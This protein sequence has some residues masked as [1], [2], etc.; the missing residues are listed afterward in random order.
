MEQQFIEGKTFN[1]A[2]FTKNGLPSGDYDGCTF[3]NL[4][5]HDVNFKGSDMN[6]PV[7]DNCCLRTVLSENSN[8]EKCDFRTS[9]DY[10]PDPER[11][12][13]RKSR[14]SLSVITGLLDKHYIER[15][16]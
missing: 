12:R 5:L 9:V 16:P 7:F 11:N 4:I 3:N 1:K 13:I 10:S 15:D 6:D 8:L 14:F 2:G